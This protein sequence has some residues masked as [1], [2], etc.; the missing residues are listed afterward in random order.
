MHLSQVNY[1]FLAVSVFKVYKAKVR[2]QK[3]SAEQKSKYETAR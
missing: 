3:M 1:F 2:H